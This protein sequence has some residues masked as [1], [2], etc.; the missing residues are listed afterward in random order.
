[1]FKIFSV[2]LVL[3]LSFLPLTAFSAEWAPLGKM[4]MGGMNNVTIYVDNTSIK[5][6][7]RSADYKKSWV[8]FEL[9]KNVKSDYSD[10]FYRS[11]KELYYFHCS[12]GLYTVAHVMLID[13]DDKVIY[14]S[15]EFD[16]FTT[17]FESSWKLITPVSGPDLV[18]TYV[19]KLD[20]ETREASRNVPEWMRKKDNTEIEMPS[21]TKN[22]V[23]GDM[24]LREIRWAQRESGSERLVLDLYKGDEKMAKPAGYEVV[25]EARDQKFDIILN[26]YKTVETKIPDFEESTII[27][28]ILI[29][30]NTDKGSLN[31]EIKL[32]SSPSYEVFEVENPGRLV[33][34]FVPE[35]KSQ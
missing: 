32:K 33:I 19:C 31:I 21:L 35:A 18:N 11:R 5:K 2:F 12:Q 4:S 16:P 8:K 30:E 23:Q 34:D 14:D 13:A 1:M 17:E 27:R 9:P 20:D 7:E 3:T 25:D 6:D 28:E 24:N 10:D 29:T 26:G 15:G 22:T